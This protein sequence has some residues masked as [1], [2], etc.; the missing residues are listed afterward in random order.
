MTPAHYAF[1]TAFDCLSGLSCM[2][3]FGAYAALASLV[4]PSS[5]RPQA[6]KAKSS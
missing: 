1:V 2:A 6:E 5:K 3:A 4:L